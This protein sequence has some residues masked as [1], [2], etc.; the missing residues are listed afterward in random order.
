MKRFQECRFHGK[1][2]TQSQGVFRVS[3]DGYVL[4]MESIG[5][6]IKLHPSA[7][8]LYALVKHHDVF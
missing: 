4:C 1:L 8:R 2:K 3:A 7:Q 5:W 6:R